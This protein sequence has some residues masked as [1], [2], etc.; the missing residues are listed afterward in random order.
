[1]TNILFCHNEN[2]LCSKFAY[3]W[4]V[5]GLTPYIINGGGLSPLHVA[6][7]EPKIKIHIAS[8]FQ[9]PKLYS[10]ASGYSPKNKKIGCR[11]FF[12]YSPEVACSL[13][14]LFIYD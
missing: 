13:P 12:W 3:F 2:I 4:S 1:M 7:I 8:E 10:R 14:F 6:S 11:P 9:V 5:Q